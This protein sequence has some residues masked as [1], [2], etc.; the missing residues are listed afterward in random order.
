MAARAGA[1]AGLSGVAVAVFRGD[2]GPVTQKILSFA[3]I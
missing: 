1:V 3:L 2:F